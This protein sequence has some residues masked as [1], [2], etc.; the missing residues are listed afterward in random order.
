MHD[1]TPKRF[2]KAKEETTAPAMEALEHLYKVLLAI[3]P[4]TLKDGTPVRV[5]SYVP[6]EMNDQGEAECG[7]DVKLPDGHLE[8]MLKNTGWGKSFADDI[9]KQRAKKIRRR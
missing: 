5:E 4:F 3:P 1:M 6:P 8:F 7:I 2:A 9:A